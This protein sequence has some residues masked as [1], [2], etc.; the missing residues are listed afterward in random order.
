MNGKKDKDKQIF[1]ELFKVIYEKG[2]IDEALRLLNRMY[3]VMPFKEVA[4]YLPD[5]QEI[6]HEVN[7]FF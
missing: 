7:T 5:S 4:E 6:N 3:K 1:F 2:E